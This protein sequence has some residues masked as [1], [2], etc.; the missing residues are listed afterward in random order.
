VIRNTRVLGL[1]V[2]LLAVATIQVLEGVFLWYSFR[3]E[4]VQLT[5]LRE[6]LVDEGADMIRAQL[7]AERIRGAIAAADSLLHQRRQ[8]V[9]PQGQRARAA[10]RSWTA[11]HA[12]A[13]GIDAFN[14]EVRR[15]N[16]RLGELN[17]VVMRRNAAAARYYLLA[18]SIRTLAVRAGEPYFSVP[19]PAQAAAERGITRDGAHLASGEWRHDGASALRENR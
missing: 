1:L 4:R 2:F 6:E 10:T 9:D 13:E 3:E 8:E 18:D 12:H 14:R 7:E 19:I 15:R 5:Q 16:E 17:A 11:Y